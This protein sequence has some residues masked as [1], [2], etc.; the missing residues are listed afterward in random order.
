MGLHIMGMNNNIKNLLRCVA[1]NDLQKA[2]NKEERA[3]VDEFL[4]RCKE[5]TIL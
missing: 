1:D 2:K 3:K 4:Q 5:R